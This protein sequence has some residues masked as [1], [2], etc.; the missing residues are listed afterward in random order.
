MIDIGTVLNKFNDTVDE[1]TSETKAFGIKV[2]TA[3]GEVREMVCRKN[4]KSPKARL[5][6]EPEERGKM[7]Y[8]LK[9][10]G[11]MLVQDLEAMA[12]RSVKV[13]CILQ[14]KDFLSNH[15]EDVRH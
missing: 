10:N 15:W 7:N 14:F 2:L 4:V 12:P 5:E 11:V 9:K 8:N 13:A 1:R 6:S 3:T